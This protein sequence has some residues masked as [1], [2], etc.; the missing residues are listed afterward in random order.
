MVQKCT[1]CHI[2]FKEN[3]NSKMKDLKMKNKVLAFIQ[4]DFII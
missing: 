3:L 2:N 4:N 1:I